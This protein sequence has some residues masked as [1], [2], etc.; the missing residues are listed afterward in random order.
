MTLDEAIL[1]LTE[2]R[3]VTDQAVFLDRLEALMESS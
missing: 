1:K 2:E 3:E